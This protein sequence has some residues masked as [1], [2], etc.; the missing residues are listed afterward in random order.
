MGINIQDEETDGEVRID[1]YSAEVDQQTRRHPAL[2]PYIPTQIPFREST[3]S[4]TLTITKP[5]QEQPGTSRTPTIAGQQQPFILENV[6]IETE[7][8]PT[9]R[10]SGCS[11]VTVAIIWMDFKY[12]YSFELRENYNNYTQTIWPHS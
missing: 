4:S 7:A 9:Q 10:T 8:T 2:L 1:R 3:V 11:P 12:T 5:Q 6:Q